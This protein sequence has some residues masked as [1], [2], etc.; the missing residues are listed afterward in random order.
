MPTNKE[1]LQFIRNYYI[2]ENPLPS[3]FVKKYLTIDF[4][5]GCLLDK[6]LNYDINTWFDVL[7]KTKAWENIPDTTSFLLNLSKNL[8]DTRIIKEK[9]ILSSIPF[10]SL[11]GVYDAIFDKDDFGCLLYHPYI[12]PFLVLKIIRLTKQPTKEMYD[13]MCVNAVNIVNIIKTVP[14]DFIDWKSVSLNTNLTKEFIEE[15]ILKL[16]Q[17]NLNK[18]YPD[19]NYNRIYK[20]KEKEYID[21]LSVVQSNDTQNL[22]Q[23]FGTLLINATKA[24]LPETKPATP[25]ASDIEARNRLLRQQLGSN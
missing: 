1:L 10:N 12:E 5:N 19:K 14:E 13:H 23:Q 6:E 25:D 9:H 2:S 3:E 20:K 7:S 11:L 16:N 18:T 17:E 8:K 24:Q 15:N 22:L 4:I 21:S